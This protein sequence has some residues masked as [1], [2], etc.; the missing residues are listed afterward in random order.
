MAERLNICLAQ[1]APSWL[2]KQ[3]GIKKIENAILE[4]AEN[5][6][7][8]IA[9]PEAYLP[10]YPF[11]LDL[12]HA[13]KFNS[14]I[15]KEI[16]AHYLNE[17]VCIENGDLQ[18]ILDQCAK[19]NIACILGIIEAPKDRAGHSLYCSAVYI[20]NKGEIQNVHRKLVPTYEERLVWGNGDGHGLKCFQMENFT[21]GVLNCWENWMPLARTSLYAQGENVHFALWPG[22]LR[23]TELITPFIAQESRSYSI[24][25]SAIMRKSDINNDIPHPEL[26]KM[27]APDMIANGGSCVSNPDGSWLLEPQVNEENLY[28]VQ[29]DL[30]EIRKE[31]QN[32]DPSGHYSRPD[33]FSLSLNTERQSL[34]KKSEGKKKGA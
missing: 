23:N 22:N 27:E 17:A 21:I 25:V 8:I 26:I 15:Q 34:F 13:S 31:R 1:L 33:V 9:F 20:N 30:E 2:D 10:G 4:S 32:F 11:W 6:A 14:E 24:A 18:S 16:F 7:H 3:K 5:G 29:I 12:T 19:S 28:I